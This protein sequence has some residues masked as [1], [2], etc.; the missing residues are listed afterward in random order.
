MAEVVVATHNPGKLVELR[1][2]LEALAGAPELVL[3]S[4]AELGLPVPAE[5]GSSFAEN[6]RAKA[7]QAAA[8]SG[9]AAIADDSG[10]EVDALGGAPGI[11]SAHYAGE[12]ADA[13][14]NNR[15]LLAA[16]AGVPWGRR[17]ARF[18]CAVALAVPVGAADEPGAGGAGTGGARIVAEAEGVLEGR[19]AEAPRGE[20]GF[21]YDPLFVPAGESRTLA[22]LGAAYK[23]R[24]SHRARALAALGE[25]LARLVPAAGGAAGRAGPGAAGVGERGA[26]PRG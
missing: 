23:N 4:S 1:A 21:G 26:G 16:L 17:T 6:A 19:I 14:A 20:A 13:E 10:L 24:H 2:I 8:A 18:R 25:A 12:G 11:G 9:R 3:R 15:K 22:E 5:R 7:L